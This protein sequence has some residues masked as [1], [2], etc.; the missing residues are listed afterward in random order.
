MHSVM[1]CYQMFRVIIL[2]MASVSVVGCSSTAHE[3]I[4]LEDRTNAPQ[5]V[6]PFL[7][8]SKMPKAM[9]PPMSPTP[10]P[11]KQK[12]E[13]RKLIVPGGVVTQATIQ[14][15]LPNGVKDAD[16]WAKDIKVA[17][18]ALR[19]PPTEQNICAVLAVTEQES[20]FNAD[21]PVAGLPKIVRSEIT[22]R[23]EKFHLPEAAVNFAFSVKSP[24]GR[25]YAERIDDLRTEND[26]NKL[27]ADMTSELPL[28]K[29]LLESYNPIRTGGPMQVSLK[30]AESQVKDN[31]YPYSIKSTL[32][33]ELFTRRGGIYFGTAY[34]LDYPASYDK[35]IYRFADFNAGRYAS[36][37]AAFQAAVSR[38]TGSDLDCDG[39]LLRYENGGISSEKSQTQKAVMTLMDQL[40]LSGGEIANDLS[41]EKKA[42][43]EKTQLFIRVFA[44]AG[45]S[46]APLPKAKLP[47]IKLNSPKISNG[48]TTS[49]FAVRVNERFKGCLRR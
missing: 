43:F 6:D 21:P 30:F 40:D 39:D 33:N 34:L 4:E 18:E 24:D 35:M 9:S 31:P 36:R 13:D 45:G 20:S 25:T 3:K 2:I 29:Q 1:A 7:I 17:F 48:L 28:G 14:R 49:K 5:E 42:G 19:L 10:L 26:L 37:N 15:M 23:A 32:R 12:N 16:G 46:I 38:L 41:K 11:I 8:P 27:Y 47:E 22:K 44:L